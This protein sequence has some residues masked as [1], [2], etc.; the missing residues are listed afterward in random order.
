MNA[1]QFGISS[2]VI[3]GSLL[4]GFHTAQKTVFSVEDRET[5][6][7]ERETLVVKAVRKVEASVVNISTEKVVSVR[8][9][10]PFGDDWIFDYFSPFRRSPRDVTRQSLGSGVL[11]NADGTIL[12][13]EHVIL[14]ASKITV[15]LADGR[16]YEAELIGASR[17]F[18][19]ALLKIDAGEPLPYISPGSSSDLMTGETVIAI[20]NPYGLASTVTT[21]VL[22]AKER[23]VTFQDQ[24]TRQVHS[25]HNFLQTDASINPGNSGGPLLNILGELIGINTAIIAHAEGIGFAIPIDKAKRIIDDLV[26]LGDVPRIWLGL[27]VQDIT[28]TLAQYMGL[29]R[30]T[31]VLVSEIR[32]DSPAEE[33]GLKPGDVITS[34]NGVEIRTRSDF[35]RMLRSFAPGEITRIAFVRNGAE[36]QSEITAQAVPLDRI[37]EL[38]WDTFGFELRDITRHDAANFG[39]KVTEGALVNAVRPGSPAAVVGIRQGD[40]IARMNRINIQSTKD[41][42][43][44]MPF[45]VQQDSAILV[46]VRGH[47]AYR[48]N[49]MIY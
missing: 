28:E 26:E 9:F 40:V 35:R 39:L 3:L 22:S 17:R 5:F 12:T 46:V 41:F 44:Q 7:V 10:N 2:I 24:E 32:N 20:G 14:P 16:E 48:V 45:V 31:G 37:E 18:D 30:V 27:Q 1:K 36:K 42:Y 34:I 11:I 13:N 43:Q 8:G 49:V 6:R 38:T 21:G 19:L 4:I 47:N 23:T 29:H 25:F 33:S 15:T